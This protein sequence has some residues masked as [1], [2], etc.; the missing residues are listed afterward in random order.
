MQVFVVGKQWMWKVQ[1]MEGVREINALHV[2]L[3]RAVKLTMTSEDVIHSFYVP[4]FRIKQDVLPG[5]YTT[6]WFKAT[7]IGKYHLFCAEYCGTLHSGMIGTVT[8][9][10]PSDYEAWLSG[11]KGSGQSL[12]SAGEQLFQQL[13][14]VTCHRN[15]GQGRG[16][17]LVQLPGKTV[18]LEDGR[19]VVA[20]EAYLRESI[21]NSQAKI[22]AG[23][24]PIMPTFK[25]LVSEEGLMQLI[26]Y[27]KTLGGPEGAAAASASAAAS[28]GGH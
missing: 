20:D 6:A 8:V 18:K 16:P 26:A 27:I 5:R 28:T 17:S 23:Y 11:G 1:H 13:G 25:G 21:L 9:M 19:T 14:C 4:A 12:A 7:K 22:V 10:E 2:P 3:G 15:D 24:K